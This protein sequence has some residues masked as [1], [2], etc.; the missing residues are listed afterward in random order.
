MLHFSSFESRKF[1]RNLMHIFVQKQNSAWHSAEAKAVTNFGEM[2]L[3]FRDRISPS[4]SFF[5]SLINPI[6]FYFFL[7]T[8][9]IE[10]KAPANR[11]VTAAEAVL[12]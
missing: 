4:S 8:Q 10:M 12:S 2:N 5:S 3:D 9:K 7:R 6:I 1:S 11:K